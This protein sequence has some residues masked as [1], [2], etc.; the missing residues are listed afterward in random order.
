MGGVLLC[1]LDNFRVVKSGWFLGVWSPMVDVLMSVSRRNPDRENCYCCRQP[2]WSWSPIHR[3]IYF[4]KQKTIFDCGVC[5]WFF[6]LFIYLGYSLYCL[7]LLTVFVYFSPKLRIW[8]CMEAGPDVNEMCRAGFGS[9]LWNPCRFCQQN[10]H[11]GHA[12]LQKS[13]NASKMRIPRGWS[14]CEFNV[15]QCAARNFLDPPWH[16]DSISWLDHKH[17]PK[18]WSFWDRKS[19]V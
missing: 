8:D 13:L 19:V 2:V 16:S 14:R 9:V 15:P 11:F 4:C 18:R 6:F 7:Y 3:Y 5:C 12:H 10:S 17:T 1:I